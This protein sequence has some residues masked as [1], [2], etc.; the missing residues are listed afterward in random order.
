MGPCVDFVGKAL[1]FTVRPEPRDMPLFSG[2]GLG[3]VRYSGSRCALLPCC[4]GDRGSFSWGRVS[5]LL[6]TVITSRLNSPHSCEGRIGIIEATKCTEMQLL[7]PFSLH[8]SAQSRVICR[9]SFFFLPYFLL[10]LI[11]LLDRGIIAIANSLVLHRGAI[12]CPCHA[13][14][15]NPP[16]SEQRLLPPWPCPAVSDFAPVTSGCELRRLSFQWRESMPE[17][18]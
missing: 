2:A 1:W 12:S 18:R 6:H 3:T 10:F 11:H 16:V 4:A 13:S 14:H 9:M 8:H 5:D 7:P 17:G 15:L